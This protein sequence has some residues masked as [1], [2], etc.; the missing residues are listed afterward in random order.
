MIV[1]CVSYNC[2]IEDRIVLQ[3]SRSLIAKGITKDRGR[4]QGGEFNYTRLDTPT[5][6]DNY[7]PQE[8]D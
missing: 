5:L 6:I 2:I 7:T 8:R 3:Q 4:E 1:I